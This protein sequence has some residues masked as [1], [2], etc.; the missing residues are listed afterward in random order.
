MGKENENAFT[1]NSCN[2]MDELT[3]KQ[4]AYGVAF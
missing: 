2:P 1:F 4:A 3:E